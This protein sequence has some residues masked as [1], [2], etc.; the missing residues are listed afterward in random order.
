MAEPTESFIINDYNTANLNKAAFLLTK[1]AR[2]IS[3]EIQENN[4]GR[5]YLENV[6]KRHVDEY[7]KDDL[8]VEFWSYSR[9]REFLKNHL[10]EIRDNRID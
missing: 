2:Y 3:C 9:S 7:W 5:F 6:N 8:M 10:R 4:M 1:G